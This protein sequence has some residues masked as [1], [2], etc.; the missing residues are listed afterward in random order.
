MNTTTSAFN[1]SHARNTVTLSEAKGL[2]GREIL[3]FAQDDSGG[4]GERSH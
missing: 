4:D 1:L 3:R 2:I